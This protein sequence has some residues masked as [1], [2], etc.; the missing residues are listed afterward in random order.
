MNRLE[1]WPDRAH[2]RRVNQLYFVLTEL[3]TYFKS[4]IITN[5]NPKRLQSTPQNI[6]YQNCNAEQTPFSENQFDFF[7]IV[8]GVGAMK[9]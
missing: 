7:E 1:Y 6:H 3:S 2:L 9:V 5:S 8:W 4:I